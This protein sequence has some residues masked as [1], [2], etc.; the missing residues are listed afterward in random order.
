MSRTRA[1]VKRVGDN[2]RHLWLALRTL[3]LCGTMSV[4][5]ARSPQRAIT[6]VHGGADIQ[7]D[8]GTRIWTLRSGPAEYRLGPS[9][10][11]TGL[12]YF[13]PAGGQSWAEPLPRLRRYARPEVGGQIEGQLLVP[14]ELD[15]TNSSIESRA[16]DRPR[17]T[18]TYRHR[19][20]PLELRI[21][22]TA[23]G[24]TAVF[25]RSL[26]LVNRGTRPLALEA[27][28][29]LTW[30]LPG[31]EYSL[32][33][34]HGTWGEERQLTSEPLGPGRREFINHTGRSSNGYSPWFCLHDETH[35]IRY[36]AQLAYSGNW[37]MGF[38]RFTE[39]RRIAPA[40]ADLSAE[41]GLRADLGGPVPLAPGASYDL[42]E[43]AF[44]VSTGDLDDVSNQLHRYQRRYIEP[45][46]PDRAPL[47]T[48]FNTWEPLG[49]TATW[50]QMKPYLDLAAQLG[51]EAFGPDAAWV[52][53]Q[54]G[55]T[56]FGD[57]RSDPAG[58]PHGLRE[59]ADAVHA[60]GMKFVLWLEPESTS[61][62]APMAR[63]HP[64]WILQYNGVPM[65]GTYDRVYWDFRHPEV[66]AWARKIVDRMV[67]EEKIDWL[68]LDY[69]A[70][71]GERFDPADSQ[72][73]GSVLKEH[74]RALDAWLDA[75]RTDY[76]QLIVENCS[77]GGLRENLDLMA[78]TH[79]GWLSDVVDPRASCQ[80]AYGA[81]VEFAP[82]YCF[83]WMAGDGPAGRVDNAGAPGWWDFMFRIAMNGPFAISSRILDWTP[84]LKA[85]AAANLA[86][87]RRIRTVIAGSDV[88]H[89]TPPPAVGN[90]PIGWMALQYV[91]PA[92]TRSVVMTYRLA[93]SEPERVIKLRGL[94]PET[95][96][97]ILLNG[98]PAKRQTGRELMTTGIAI[99]LQN[100][101]RSEVVELSAET[102]GWSELP[103]TRSNVRPR[104]GPN[105]E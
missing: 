29:S 65:E 21:R 64:D 24:D 43:A 50:A 70:D 99:A 30:L 58:F 86:L 76:P 31:G 5:G 51:L 15:L 47:P 36:A 98:R 81:T 32:D 79:F 71:V 95:V 2:A 9:H 16:A 78:R 17:L 101:W 83:H 1:E 102:R 72:R 88:Y 75:I 35:G 97:S 40:E 13:G 68:K 61:K 20:L 59:V 10:G 4:G 105:A 46:L 3:A 45:T 62:F 33:Y 19:H 7:F 26:T 89:L 54:Q 27:T 11:A 52:V 8:S 103:S 84:A 53:K 77:S 85:R 28:P 100:E 37:A 91:A 34:L 66:R 57:W 69:N 44:T 93:A 67:R 25:S 23:W 82:D 48:Q 92:G 6:A 42:P 74:L 22:Y 14:E 39:R 49:R 104:S 56:I 87:Y 60:K 12:L 41:I 73:T 96:Y 18:L 90:H 94:E 63:S 38:E 80:L 55:K